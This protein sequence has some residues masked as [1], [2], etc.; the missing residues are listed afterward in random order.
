MLRVRPLSVAEKEAGDTRSLS[1]DEC[2][3][4]SPVARDAAVALTQEYAAAVPLQKQLEQ[5]LLEGAYWLCGAQFRQ[6]GG[7]SRV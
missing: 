1:I 6:Q 2:V 4:P 7:L 3:S 5:D